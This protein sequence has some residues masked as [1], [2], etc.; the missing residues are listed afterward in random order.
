MAEVTGVQHEVWRS[1][2]RIDLGDRFLQRAD[3]ILVRVFVKTDVAVADLHKAEIAADQ[4]SRR[5][6]QL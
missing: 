3:H 1:R 5:A 4:R 2:Q 6:E